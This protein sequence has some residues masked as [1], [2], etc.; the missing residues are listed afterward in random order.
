MAQNM[1]NID[2]LHIFYCNFT[3]M[4]STE[5]KLWFLSYLEHFWP[6]P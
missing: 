5:E 4:V 2:F 3:T 1:E 6:D